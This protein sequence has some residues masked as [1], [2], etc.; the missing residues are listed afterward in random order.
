MIQQL[1]R[2]YHHEVLRARLNRHGH[3]WV[4][5]DSAEHF[6]AQDR[7]VRKMLYHEDEQVRKLVNFTMIIIL[8]LNRNYTVA[9][10]N[11]SKAV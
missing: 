7:R 1:G 5:I 11:T 10:E 6:W 2:Y 9:S 3:S 8:L 4:S